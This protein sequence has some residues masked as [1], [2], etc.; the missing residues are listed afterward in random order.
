MKLVNLALD[1][2]FLGVIGGWIVVG[3]VSA[4]VIAC[5]AHSRNK[6]QQKWVKLHMKED[7]PSE[8]YYDE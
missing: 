7:M 5:I 2:I 6:K 8:E 4:I 1:P 3:I